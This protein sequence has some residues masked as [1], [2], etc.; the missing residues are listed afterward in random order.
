[1]AMNIATFNKYEMNSL[2]GYTLAQVAVKDGVMRLVFMSKDSTKAARAD[3]LCD[4]EGN[5]PGY[6]EVLH[7]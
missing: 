1:M 4:E 2:I 6:A 7:V 5:G 3:I